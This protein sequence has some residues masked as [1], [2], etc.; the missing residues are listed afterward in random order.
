MTVLGLGAVVVSLSAQTWLVFEGFEGD[1]PGT[2]SVGDA[3]PSGIPAYW[4]KVNAPF[5]GRLPFSGQWKGYCAGVGYSGTSSEPR[6]VT[7]MAAYLSR[8]VNLSGWPRANL[9]FRSLLASINANSDTYRVRLDDRILW[10]NGPALARWEEVAINLNDHV[11]GS[12]TLR[13]EFLSGLDLPTREGWYLDDIEVTGASV[14]LAE[15]WTALE[16]TN[17]TGYV[18][19]ADRLT[20]HPAFHRDALRVQTGFAAEN[21]TPAPSNLTY[22]LQY[23]LLDSA[24]APFPIFDLD[25]SIRLNFT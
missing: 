17:Y 5:G 22:R 24:G 1:F 8:V 10:T 6:Y 20:N 2:W 16:L 12:R 4:W 9:R 13:F 18:I 25:G 11:G 19:D 14:P 3:N 23:R 21:F 7:F 15:Q